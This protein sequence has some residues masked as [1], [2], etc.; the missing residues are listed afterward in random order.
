MNV[1]A[2]AD[3]SGITN[4]LCST[5]LSK[6]SS[7][8]WH[9]CLLRFQHADAESVEQ[10]DHH[11]AGCDAGALDRGLVGEQGD[12]SVRDQW[13]AEHLR[14]EEARHEGGDGAEAGRVASDEKLERGRDPPQTSRI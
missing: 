9:S 3:A 10:G 6:F 8:L 12:G 13:V 5:V 11:H 1:K 7:V 14:V 4:C 2:A